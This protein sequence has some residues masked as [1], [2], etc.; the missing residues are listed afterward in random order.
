MQVVKILIVKAIDTPMVHVLGQE[1]VFY[2]NIDSCK[3]T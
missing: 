1:C 3:M 2:R